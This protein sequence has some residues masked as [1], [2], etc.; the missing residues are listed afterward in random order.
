MSESKESI[1]LKELIDTGSIPG[2]GFF[3]ITEQ[4]LID[5]ITIYH[6][7]FGSTNLATKS[8]SNTKFARRLAGR[9]LVRLNSARGA[10][11]NQIK[12]GLLYLIG[13]P[14]FSLHYKVGITLD[15][16]KRL[17][18]YQTYSPF[19]DFTLIKY[20]FVLDRTKSEKLVLNNPNIT[21][22]QG[23]WILKNNAIHIFN[24]LVAN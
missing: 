4:H 21:K 20:D 24:A 2:T 14:A 15:V 10:K 17:A 12:A 22:E 19:R 18:Q 6:K 1:V 5:Y 13:N 23:E 8:R 16:S 11:F 7:L 3:D 9:T